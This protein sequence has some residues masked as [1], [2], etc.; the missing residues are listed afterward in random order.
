MA[1]RRLICSECGGEILGFFAASPRAAYCAGC[2]EA[3]YDLER[4]ASRQLRD[5]AEA[6]GFVP[7]SE[8]EA[9]P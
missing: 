8:T 9:R 6:L 5:K 3:M 1:E 2:V 7:L 4:S